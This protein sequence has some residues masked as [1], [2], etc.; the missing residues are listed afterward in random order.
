MLALNIEWK[1]LAVF[2]NVDRTTYFN[3][4]SNFRRNFRRFLKIT[5]LNGYLFENACYMR[6]Q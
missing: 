3:S 6:R 2:Y 5:V 4:S 1:L